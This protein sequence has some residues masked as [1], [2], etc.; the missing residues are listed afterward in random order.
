MAGPSCRLHLCSTKLQWGMP[1]SGK[2]EE[3][4]GS[5]QGHI[6]LINIILL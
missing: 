4:G 3:L 2:R 6:I 5:R 1:V